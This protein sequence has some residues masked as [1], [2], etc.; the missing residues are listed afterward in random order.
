MKFYLQH[1][2]SITKRF[3]LTEILSLKERERFL[4]I[5]YF[6]NNIVCNFEPYDVCKIAIIRTRVG[7]G[8]VH[9]KMKNKFIS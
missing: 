4:I 9:N 3:L 2:L 1:N 6:R 5:T 8:G 7:R